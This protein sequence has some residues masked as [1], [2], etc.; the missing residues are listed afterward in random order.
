MRRS[1]IVWLAGVALA[2]AGTAHAA[3]L[4]VCEGPNGVK[5]YQDT[6]CAAKAKTVGTSTFKSSPYAPPATPP[7]REDETTAQ[8]SQ[9]PP[10]PL[11][12]VAAEPVGWICTAGPRRW[13]QFSPCPA[14]YMRP[15]AASMDGFNAQ[16]GQFMH[17]TGTVNIPTPV[18]SQPL[19]RAGVCLAAG[20]HSVQI[21]HS[22][23][24]DVYERN[25]LKSKYCY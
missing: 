23:S 22:G 14:T 9:A 1:T 16:T 18:E 3:T 7:P 15:S 21:H 24:S 20:D 13:L 12:A 25:V 11:P 6:P 8:T 2:W 17:G 5:A 19:T 4:Y 10:A